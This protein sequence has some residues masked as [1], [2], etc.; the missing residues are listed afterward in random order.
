ML[1][2]G[3]IRFLDGLRGRPESSGV[4]WGPFGNQVASYQNRPEIFWDCLGAVCG[5]KSKL[6]FFQNC[7][8]LPKSWRF[9]TCHLFVLRDYSF[10][11]LAPY[12]GGFAG[13]I[14]F[15]PILHFVLVDLVMPLN[16]GS[17][18]ENL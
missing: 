2:T 8:L 9:H 14:R 3:N 7:S 1:E 16:V 6:H 10:Q 13:V 5:S 4:V 17:L 18:V 15:V 12:V 11:P